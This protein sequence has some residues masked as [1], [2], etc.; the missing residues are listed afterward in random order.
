ML[1]QNRQPQYILGVD[2]VWHCGTCW[3]GRMA[4]LEN[5]ISADIGLHEW[6]KIY[7]E[8]PASQEPRP[9]P[10]GRPAVKP[11]RLATPK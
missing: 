4:G 10:T 9:L 11:D 8:G 1:A 6:I 3:R 7:L 2:M 5:P